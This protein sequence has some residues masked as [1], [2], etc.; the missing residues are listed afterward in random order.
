MG[1]I[2]ADVA[3][4]QEAHRHPVAGIQVCGDHG[5]AAVLTVLPVLLD[6]VAHDRAVHLQLGA[7]GLGQVNRRQA[8]D[9]G[10]QAVD[11]RAGSGEDTSLHV[12]AVSQ[13]EED[14]LE[15]DLSVIGKGAKAGQG[16]YIVQ[17]DGEGAAVV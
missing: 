15:G 13:V 4:S 14:V 3:S 7:G 16:V 5:G 17:G 9:G 1:V 11:A 12:V 8:V 10:R 2:I 6:E